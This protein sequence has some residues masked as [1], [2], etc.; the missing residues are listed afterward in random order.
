[1]PWMPN[2]FH[3]KIMITTIL[4]EEVLRASYGT[5]VHEDY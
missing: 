5:A 4:V 1:M 3:S 2:F